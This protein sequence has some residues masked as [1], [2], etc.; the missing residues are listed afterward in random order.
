[1]KASKVIGWVAIIVAL[2]AW[3]AP[4]ALPVTADSGIAYEPDMP[5]TGPFLSDELI[6]QWIESVGMN[7]QAPEALPASGA[8]SDPDMP[9]VAPS[10]SDDLIRQWLESVGMGA[11]APEAL[12]GS[13][14]T[15]D[16]D[17]PTVAPSLGDD[18]IRQWLESAR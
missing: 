8:A 5:Y 10:L 18:L 1:M 7:D 2:A 3:A 9:T 14:T 12:P 4:A 15:S 17:M 16:P 6:N 11:Q 13:G